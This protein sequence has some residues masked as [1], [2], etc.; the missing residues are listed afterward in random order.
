MNKQQLLTKYAKFFAA[1]PK[2]NSPILEG[3]HY[4]AD[5]SA[6]VLNR[7]YLLR[8]RGA[9]SMPA[10]VTLHHKTGQAIEGVY[11]DTSKLWPRDYKH[12]VELHD[13][14]QVMDSAVCAAFCAMQPDKKEPPAVKLAMNGSTALCVSVDRAFDL[15][16]GHIAEWSKKQAWETISL[17]GQYLATALQL[18]YDAGRSPIKLCVTGPLNPIVLS[19]AEDIDILILP[20]RIPN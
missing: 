2:Q 12:E 6:I 16:R 15:Y 1:S 14:K 18:F 5:G 4:A 7:H 19:D 10:A 20:Y 17:N 11:P 13:L 3:I 8:I 9:H